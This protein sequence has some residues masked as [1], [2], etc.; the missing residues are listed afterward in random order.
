MNSQVRQGLASDNDCVC[1]YRCVQV[2]VC[3]YVLILR[4]CK[5]VSLWYF[6]GWG[7]KHTKLKKHYTGTPQSKLRFGLQIRKDLLL[8]LLIL[9]PNIP[10]HTLPRLCYHVQPAIS[11][12]FP[13]FT[14]IPSIGRSPIILALAQTPMALRSLG[15]GGAVESVTEL[16]LTQSITLERLCVWWSEKRSRGILDRSTG[17]YHSCAEETFYSRGRNGER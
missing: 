13:R 16:E 9:G 14:H 3:A 1:A 5:L 8:S 12:T 15:E 6:G 7:R 11:D 4:K 10:T 17:L 2:Y